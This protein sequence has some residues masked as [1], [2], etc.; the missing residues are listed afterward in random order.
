MK[1][2]AK[3]NINSPV[4]TLKN[5]LLRVL[6]AGVYILFFRFS[7][8][9]FFK[10]RTF[11]LKMFGATIGKGVAIYPSATI[12]LPSN[13]HVGDKVAIGPNVT[14]YNQGLITIRDRAIISQG[15]HLCA[16]THDYNDPLHPLKLAPI[17]IKDNVWICADSFIGP[18]VTV[19]KG[20]VVGA[21]SVVVK[22]VD[23]WSVY[24]GNPALK[25]KNRERF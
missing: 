16:S 18:Y 11:I 4:F 9:P 21:R 17:V 7:P 15:C 19:N 3:T 13:L 8:K 1:V 14:I 20:A 25:I 2:K 6:W 23:E 5:K 22:S 10:Y 12:W 24:G